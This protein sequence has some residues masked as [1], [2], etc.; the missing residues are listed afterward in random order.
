MCY[1]CIV[2]QTWQSQFQETVDDLILQSNVHS[3]TPIKEPKMQKD[4]KGKNKIG[5]S[6]GP[7]GCLNEDVECSGWFPQDIVPE[8][9]VDNT[10]GYIRLKKW[11]SMI[12]TIP[13]TATYLL[14]CNTDVMGLLSGTSIKAI[15]YYITNYVTKQSLKTYQLFSSAYDV[16]ESNPSLFNRSVKCKEAARKLILKIANALSFKLEIGSPMASL[17]LLANPDHYTSHTFTIFWWKSYVSEVQN[18]WKEYS[19]N[20]NNESFTLPHLF[21]PES[22]Q[23]IGIQGGFPRIWWTFLYMVFS[24]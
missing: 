13:P 20:A 16:F 15:V 12:N 11:D 3:C 14:R 18:N 6:N 7:K 21:R 23:N 9:V 5:I 1:Q 17:Y 19:N 8:S 24:L 10:D 2:L 4:A 22:G